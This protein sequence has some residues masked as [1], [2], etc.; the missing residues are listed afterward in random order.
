MTHKTKA[1]ISGAAKAKKK[2]AE[3]QRKQNIMS[4]WF[5]S[6]VSEMETCF[7]SLSIRHPW[8][9]TCCAGGD[10]SIATSCV[11]HWR[12]A[13]CRPPSSDDA[14]VDQLFATYNTVLRGIVDRLVPQHNIR[15]PASRLS[16]WFDAE[17]RAQRRQCRRLERRYRRT[18]NYT[19]RRSWVDAS[20]RRILLHRQKKEEY[21]R[22]GTLGKLWAVID[23]A[24]ALAVDATRTAS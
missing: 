13:S 21:W 10:A 4:T 8:W 19:D 15:R 1:N 23:N 20:R 18:R 14:D 16:P 2:K 6:S 3:S 22:A 12:T 9:R 17:C 7:R 24:L 5:G 11:E